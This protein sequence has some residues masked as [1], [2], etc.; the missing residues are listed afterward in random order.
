MK[1]SYLN[2]MLNLRVELVVIQKKKWKI[3]IKNPQKN[4]DKKK[5]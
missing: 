3:I 1:N 5:N 2:G 4:K